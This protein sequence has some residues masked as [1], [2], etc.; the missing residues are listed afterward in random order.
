MSKHYVVDYDQYDDSDYDYEN[1]KRAKKMHQEHRRWNR[2]KSY[3]QIDD[4]DEAQ[5]LSR[6]MPR[7]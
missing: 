5:D 1:R 2:K 3:E 7:R 4:L 6:V